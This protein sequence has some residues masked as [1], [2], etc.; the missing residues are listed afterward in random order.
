[1]FATSKFQ[2]TNLKIYQTGKLLATTQHR[3]QWSNVKEHLVQ[4]LD[5][6]FH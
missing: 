6:Q 2:R 1:M 3:A 4:R 5:V